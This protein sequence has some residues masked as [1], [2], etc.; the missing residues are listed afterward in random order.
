ML[1]KEP[2]DGKGTAEGRVFGSRMRQARTTK[3]CTPEST[4]ALA[5][6]SVGLD[7]YSTACVSSSLELALVVCRD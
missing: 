2:S 6:V 4:T 3:Y 1:K 7:G 5:F